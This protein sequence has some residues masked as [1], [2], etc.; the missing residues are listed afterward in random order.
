MAS[1]AKLFCPDIE[2]RRASRIREAGRSERPAADRNGRR[3][4]DRREALDARARLPIPLECVDGGVQGLPIARELLQRVARGAGADDGDEI[5]RAELLVDEAMQRVAHRRI[6]LERRPEIVDDDHDRPLHFAGGESLG[7]RR[8]GR[9]RR[10]RAGARRWAGNRHPS[11][12]RDLLGSAVLVDVEVVGRRIGD[13][14]AVLVGDDGVQPDDVD[15][16][17]EAWRVR[18]SRLAGASRGTRR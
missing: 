14:F 3:L 16:D 12:E 13:E 6:A 1:A 9:W 17:S 18:R 10:R 5:V 15:G 7:R 8:P 2:D 4:T 11:H